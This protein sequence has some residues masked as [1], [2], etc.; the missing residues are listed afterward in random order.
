MIFLAF[1]SI[2]L[3]FLTIGLRFL[4][5]SPAPTPLPFAQ[6]IEMEGGCRVAIFR[7]KV[8]KTESCVRHTRSVKEVFAIL[9]LVASVASRGQADFVDIPDIPETHHHFEFYGS[10][11]KEGFNLHP[12]YLI[13][14]TG[15]WIITRLEFARAAIQVSEELPWR[16]TKTYPAYANLPFFVNTWR[17]GLLGWINE[18]A[19]E[20]RK[21]KNDPVAMKRRVHDLAPE[22]KRYADQIRKARGGK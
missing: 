3:A 22:V 17:Q 7:V 12:N 5:L 8:G 2:F 11:L 10:C 18:F 20:I 4:A 19:P 1:L 21:L 9:L 16:M 6:G 15:P 13:R 14:G